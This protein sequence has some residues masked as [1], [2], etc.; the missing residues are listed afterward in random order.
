MKK[1]ITGLLAAFG[2]ISGI[3]SIISLPE[4]LAQLKL[5]FI[6]S[7]ILLLGTALILF[8]S[9]SID[10]YNIWNIATKSKQLGIQ[11]IHKT[12]TSGEHTN[13]RIRNA[14]TIKIFSTAS[15]ILFRTKEEEF[16]EAL[17]NNCNILVIISEAGSQYLEEI[18][19]LENRR[20][21]EISDELQQ[22]FSIFERLKKAAIEKSNNQSIGKI[23][24]KQFNTQLR[25]PMIICDDEY[26][27]VTLTLSPKRSTQSASFELYRKPQ[28]SLI[29]DFIKHFD[30]IWAYLSK[31]VNSNQKLLQ[32]ANDLFSSS[33]WKLEF[34]VGNQLRSEIFTIKNG[35]EYWV[36]GKHYF[37]LDQFSID[38]STGKVTFR[39]VP[40]DQTRN[41]MVNELQMISP[42]KLIGTEDGHIN[43]TYYK[44]D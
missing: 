18:E 8:I 40:T 27:W 1:I 19:T 33:P 2:V 37:N 22:V 3:A 25:V 26:A 15:L 43:V 28:K 31:S 11:R 10:L 44:M 23:T 41:K 13:K 36:N 34:K 29:D 14:K 42:A 38:A 9:D 17:S 35:I 21:G 7:T 30:E 32:S 12:G 6:V 4:E 20:A 39:K 24:Y 5:L 16:I